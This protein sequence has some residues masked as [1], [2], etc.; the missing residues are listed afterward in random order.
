[1]CHAIIEGKLTIYLSRLS[2]FFVDGSLTHMFY[3]LPLIGYVM[4]DTTALN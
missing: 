2:S 3:L 1:M 4:V